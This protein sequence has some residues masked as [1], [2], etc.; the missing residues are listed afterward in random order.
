MR[1]LA[2]FVLLVASPAQAHDSWINRQ[3]LVDPTTGEWC[4]NSGDCFE[5]KKGGVTEV[6]GGFFVSRTGETIPH[7]RVVWRSQDGAW[8]ECLWHVDGNPRIR[9]LIGP[10]SGS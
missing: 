8:W 6:V 7:R 3:R 5:V 9:C 4:C 10:P 2:L 1:M